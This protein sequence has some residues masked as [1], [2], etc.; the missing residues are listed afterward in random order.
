MFLTLCSSCFPLLLESLI[1]HQLTEYSDIE[2]G[3]DNC[4]SQPFILSNLADSISG[5]FPILISF[6]LQSLL[7]NVLCQVHSF[8][9]CLLRVR[10]LRMSLAPIS[11]HSIV[12]SLGTLISWLLLSHHIHHISNTHSGLFESTMFL[13]NHGW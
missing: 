13:Y 9:F 6:F 11:S 12:S 3:N 8:L 7:S 4:T 1:L 10:F 2:N 5:L